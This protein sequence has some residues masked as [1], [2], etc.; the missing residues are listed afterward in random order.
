M[1]IWLCHLFKKLGDPLFIRTADGM[2]LAPRTDALIGTVRKVLDSLQRLAPAAA[3]FDPS[4]AQRRF[5]RCMTDAGHITLLPRLLAHVRALAPGVVLEAKRIDAGLAQAL[6]SGD[7]DLGVGFLPW[8]DAGFYQQI[9]YAQDWT[10]LVNAQHPRVAGNT[11]NS[12]ASWNL[13]V[14]AADAHIAISSGTCS[15]STAPWRHSN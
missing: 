2:L 7:A 12:P 6:Q 5:S 11:P 8:L 9:L 1:S 13:A 4:T 15:C 14:Y 10:C 3:Q